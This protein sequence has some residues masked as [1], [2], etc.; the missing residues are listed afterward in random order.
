MPRLDEISE[1][2]KG[3]KY[4]FQYTLNDYEKFEPTLPKLDKRIETFIKLSKTEA[5]GTDK[6]IWRYDPILRTRH[7]SLDE[8]LDRIDHIG[9][10]ISPYTDKLV[11]SFADISNYP[12]VAYTLNKNDSSARELNKDEQL[13]FARK[14]SEVNSTWEK[15]LKLTTC[16]E[17]EDLPGIDHNKCIDAALICEICRGNAEI[18]QKYG[19][20]PAWFD[21]GKLKG[22]L[23][24]KGQRKECGCALSK[25]I[26]AYNTCSHLCAYCYANH[27]Q[28]AVKSN[29]NKLS[30]ESES[31]LI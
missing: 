26:G 18:T 23:K 16:A 25:D 31:L 22:N 14:L 30:K 27:S 9:K 2:L 19:G 15:K 10:K 17:I 4:Y 21:H 28:K 7:L 20:E 24:D 29:L 8:I 13:Y 6:I 3:A 5:I 11:F 1:I 12:R